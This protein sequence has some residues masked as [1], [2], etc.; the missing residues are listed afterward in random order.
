MT[1]MGEVSVHLKEGAHDPRKNQAWTRRG[2]VPRFR[3]SLSEEQGHS[4][5]RLI[6]DG[7]GGGKL[8]P[9]HE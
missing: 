5:R 1:E 8:V 7:C 3:L 6:R 4:G 9:G 2:S